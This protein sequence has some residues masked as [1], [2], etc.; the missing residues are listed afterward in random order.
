M[1]DNLPKVV[2]PASISLSAKIPFKAIVYRETLIWRTEEFARCACDLYQRKDIGSAIVLTRVVT[3]NAAAIW[4][5]MQLIR[6]ANDTSH[7]KGLDERI[8]KLLMGSRSNDELPDAVNVLTML[9]KAEK[10]I[11]G[12]GI[13]SAYDSLS[14]FAHPNWSG[15][16]LLYSRNDHDKILTHLGKNVR[17][18]ESPLGLG[19]SSLTGSLA[20]FEHA[21][22][23][24]SDLM[25]DFVSVCEAA[26]PNNE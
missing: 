5:L 19:L 23:S 3:E 17:S 7:V 26:L 25:P 21:Y 12:I 8:M 15:T 11:P 2:D 6:D 9:K 18:A 14:E 24:I 1:T 16:S 4:Y 13:L 10:S 22:N 20:M